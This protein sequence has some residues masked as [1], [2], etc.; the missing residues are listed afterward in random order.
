[1]APAPVHDIGLGHPG[2]FI[3][4]EC[5]SNPLNQHIAGRISMVRGKNSNTAGCQFFFVLGDIPSYNRKC[6]VFGEAYDRG[7]LL[8]MQSVR[9]GTEIYSIV[10]LPESELEELLQQNPA[11]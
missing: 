2:Y 1:V 4:D 11:L 3:C 5:Q 7:S 10:I 9:V 8:L 6:T